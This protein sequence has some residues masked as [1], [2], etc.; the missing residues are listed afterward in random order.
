[1]TDAL[2]ALDAWLRR[3]GVAH[4]VITPAARNACCLA[5]LLLAAGCVAWPQA[6]WPF[7]LGV[8][9]VMAVW[10][11]GGWARFFLRRP[12]G[13]F[14]TALIR[15]VLLRFGLHLIV[16][17]AALWFVIVECAASPVALLA[18]LTL[19]LFVALATFA[20]VSR[21]EERR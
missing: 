5:L 12:L 7:W 19:G 18:G 14:S 11:L 15:V 16:P 3:M 4:P 1:M 10:L 21:R 8:G 20:A 2:D 6:R 17:A 13:A 9:A